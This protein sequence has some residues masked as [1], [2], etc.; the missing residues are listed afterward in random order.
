MRRRIVAT[1]IAGAAGITLGLLPAGSAFAS[2]GP[3]HGSGY[4][5]SRYHSHGD[6]CCG[7]NSGWNDRHS[8]CW[9]DDGWYDSGWND[10][11]GN[12]GWNDPNWH[13]SGWDDSGRNHWDGDW[14]GWN[15][16]DGWYHGGH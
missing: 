10:C 16:G 14:A 15:H 2:D 9:Y 5:Q 4:S 7:D 12:S 13:H 6:D 1:V 8:G 3:W 11:C